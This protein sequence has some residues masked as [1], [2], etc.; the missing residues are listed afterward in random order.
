[1]SIQSFD[2]AWIVVDNLKEA[3]KFY[4]EVVGLKLME[5]SEEWG[6]AELQGKT[7]ARLGIGTCNSSSSVQPGQNAVPTFSVEDLDKTLAEM[8]QRGA[9]CIGD[10]LE[11]PGHV[12]MQTVKDLDGNQFQVVQKLDI[13]G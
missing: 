6:W 2:L 7:G 11:V 1:M 8:R 5:M 10:V 13:S 3:V 4:T 12:R 9:I